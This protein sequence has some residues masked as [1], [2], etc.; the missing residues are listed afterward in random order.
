MMNTFSPGGQPKLTAC[1]FLDRMDLP[2]AGGLPRAARVAGRTRS[3]RGRQLVLCLTRSEHREQ[4]AFTDQPSA[5]EA[6]A[7][8][9]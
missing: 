4:S 2:A 3:N 9:T 1:D 6:N 5:H 7:I 8:N